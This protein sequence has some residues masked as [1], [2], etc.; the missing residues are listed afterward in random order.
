MTN[1]RRYYLPDSVVFLTVAC[2]EH[3]PLL[4]PE[5][6]KSLLLDVMREVKAEQPFAMLAWVILDD[7]FHALIRPEAPDFSRLIHAVKTRFA[8]RRKAALGIEGRAPAWQRRYWDHVIRDD[9]DLARHLD[10]IHYNPVRHGYASRPGD[11]PYSSFKEYLAREIY[12]PGWGEDVAP[13]RIEDMSLEG[14]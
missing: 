6:M 2:H 7:H 4:R 13:L 5:G 8:H 3:Q 1:I 10:Y 12:P 14:E 11:Y 9:G